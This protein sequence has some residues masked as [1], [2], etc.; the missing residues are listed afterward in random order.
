MI[1]S[2]DA[3]L[4]RQMRGSRAASGAG[5]AADSTRGPSRI[6]TAAAIAATSITPASAYS[7]AWTPAAEASGGS[8]NDAIAAPAG[9][10]V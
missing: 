2:D 4:S 7:G 6:H 8:V 9:T 5:G 1:I 3:A 10:A